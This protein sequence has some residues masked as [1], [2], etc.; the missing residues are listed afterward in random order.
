MSD[1]AKEKHTPGPWQTEANHTRGSHTFI[2]ISRGT[3][4]S[5]TEEDFFESIADVRCDNDPPNDA[6]HFPR[7][8]ANARLISAAPDLLKACERA[9]EVLHYLP[10]GLNENEAVK[11][12]YAACMKAVGK[13][14]GHPMGGD[15]EAEPRGVDG[16]TGAGKEV[17]ELRDENERLR[18]CVAKLEE[19]CETAETRL[20]SLSN[21]FSPTP[22]A[23]RVAKG[24]AKILR[25]A[26]LAADTSLAGNAS[27]E[28][29]V[30]HE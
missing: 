6:G 11:D 15:V 3:P 22:K 16:L 17:D 27:R 21:P 26:L 18:E 8:E 24:A 14:N 23:R 10:G 19:A 9:F 4:G 29:E 5:R 25:R 1:K 2:P 20:G 28:A 12:A 7:A 13:A 30:P